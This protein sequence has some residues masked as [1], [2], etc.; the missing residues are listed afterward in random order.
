MCYCCQKLEN[1]PNL[2]KIGLSCTDR[3]LSDLDLSRTLSWL[4]LSQLT[5]NQEPVLQERPRCERGRGVRE[6]EVQ[7]RPNQYWERADLCERGQLSFKIGL[8]RT[9]RPL[10]LTHVICLSQSESTASLA[11]DLSCTDWPL[12]HRSASLYSRETIRFGLS[13][14]DGLGLPRLLKSVIKIYIRSLV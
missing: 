5:A 14:P 13:L 8:S 9:D 10:P 2:L 7:E 6:A 12:L 1:W 3:P 4:A 11:H